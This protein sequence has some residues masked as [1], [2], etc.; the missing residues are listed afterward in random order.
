M[1]GRS[2]PEDQ[3]WCLQV[4]QE[5]FKEFDDLR[6]LDRAGIDLEIEVP[7][8][9]SRD[10][11]KTLPTESLLDHRSLT[12]RRPSAHSVGTR[13][14]AAFVEEDDGAAFLRGFFFSFGQT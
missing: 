14:Q 6:T 3:E 9:D 13:T 10:D 5:C 2:I 1:D 12:A 11:R 8:S 7:E 4:A